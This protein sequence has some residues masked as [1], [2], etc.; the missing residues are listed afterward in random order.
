LA[1]TRA[2]GIAAFASEMGF[3]TS[4]DT[5]KQLETERVGW[6]SFEWFVRTRDLAAFRAGHTAAGVSWCPDFGKWPEDSETCSTP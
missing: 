6:F 3:I 4:Y 5:T 2:R 1:V